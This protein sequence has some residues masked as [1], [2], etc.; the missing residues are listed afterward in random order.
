MRVWLDPKRLQTFGLTTQDV[1]NAIRGQNIEVVAGQIGGPPVPEDQ[2]FQ[3]TINALGRLSD[4]REFDAITIKAASGT[5]PQLVRLRDV[6]RVELSQQSFSN[7]SRFTGHKAA[8]I[9]VFAL[10]G[11]N[12]IQ[13]ADCFYKSMAEMKDWMARNGTSLVDVE[14]GPY[15]D[16]CSVPVTI[17]G[18]TWFAHLLPATSD[19]P[20][21]GNAITLMGV[22]RPKRTAMLATGKE[23]AVNACGDRFTIEVPKELRTEL[24]DVVVIEW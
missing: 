4:A 6:A 18:R 14:P 9:V 13:V 24:V 2:P 5:A 10:P 15:P 11:A 16:K 8:Q 19:G 21:S 3:F 1:L 7:F 23:L 22:A 12:A 17:R 20:A